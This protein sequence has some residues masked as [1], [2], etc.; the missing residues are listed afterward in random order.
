[1]QNMIRH[2]GIEH[3]ILSDAPFVGARISAIDCHNNCPGCF[4]QSLRKEP[5]KT[6]DV[7][8]IITEVINNQL[9]QGIILGGLEWSEQPDELRALVNAATQA[10]LQIIVYTHWDISSFMF[11]FPTFKDIPKLYVK[12]GDYKE[13][14]KHYYDTE[15]DVTLASDNQI[16]YKISELH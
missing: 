7:N 3:G 1:M 9:D 5:Y 13:D 16:I 14:G 12:C 15:N 4:N 11:L 2:K 8:D 6:Q 10:D